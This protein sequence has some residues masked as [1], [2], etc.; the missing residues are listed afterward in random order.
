MISKI[1]AE[2]RTVWFGYADFVDVDRHNT[3]FNSRLKPVCPLSDFYVFA[4]SRLLR[5]KV[6]NVVFI[7]HS[8]DVR[9][10][11]VLGLYKQGPGPAQAEKG[12]EEE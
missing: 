9:I 2:M 4:I 8:C 7:S 11:L 12:G 10:G 3:A 5:C 6:I 1:I